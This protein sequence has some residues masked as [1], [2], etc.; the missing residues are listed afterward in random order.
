MPSS[1]TAQISTIVDLVQI[2][3]PKSVLDVGCGYGKYGFLLQEYLMGD[4]WD[5]NRTVVD[6]VEGY[7]AYISDV[8]KAIYNQIFYCNAMN[9]GEY[10][11]RYYDVIIIIDAFEHLSVEDGKKFIEE[12]LRNC[13]YL[14]ISVPRFVGPQMGLTDDPN[15]F[16]EHR[17]F[18]TRKMFKSIN[19]CI[20]IPNNARKTIALYSTKGKF[21]DEIKKFCTKKL[22]MKFLPYVFVDFANYTK[23]F[24]NKNNENKFIKKSD[25]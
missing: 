11:K 22:Y 10:L 3:N 17:S 1:D 23:W 8:Q 21:N 20:I 6:A 15:K 25:L 4:I 14:L 19:N 13:K 5:K 2:I 12:C 7:K 9:F 16:E 24:F 18:W